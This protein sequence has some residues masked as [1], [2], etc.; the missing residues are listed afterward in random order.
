MPWQEG[1]L[2]V[3][4]LGITTTTMAACLLSTY[5]VPGTVLSIPPAWIQGASLREGD[6][7]QICCMEGETEV[8]TH[9]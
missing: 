2:E 3:Q 8:Q 9:Q 5:C 7:Y 4:T 1:R 6:C